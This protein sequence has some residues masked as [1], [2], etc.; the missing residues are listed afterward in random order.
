MNLHDLFM[1]YYE[2]LDRDEFHREFRKYMERLLKLVPNEIQVEDKP[3]KKRRVN[4]ANRGIRVKNIVKELARAKYVPQNDLRGKI[5]I[6]LHHSYTLCYLEG[7]NP[8]AYARYHVREKGWP[9][10]GYDYVCQP[11]E[12][13]VY[14]TAE[15][16]DKNYHSGSKLFTGD[17]NARYYA[18]CL[19]GN[20]DREFVTGVGYDLVI[21]ACREII[22]EHRNKTGN[23]GWVPKIVP[24]HHFAP[25]KSCPGK[26]FQVERVI[27]DVFDSTRV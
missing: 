24:H 26:N 15:L 4:L 17:E 19:S 7:S 11:L 21:Q 8:R 9:C 2:S 10:I 22:R 12:N 27:A 18:V 13:T 1:E 6:V 25:W 16:A 20:Y 23:Y 5:G 3:G 14:K